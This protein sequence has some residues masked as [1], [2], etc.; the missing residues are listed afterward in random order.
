MMYVLHKSKYFVNCP[1]TFV[2]VA[3]RKSSAAKFP[4]IKE[5]K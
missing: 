1:W 3:T 4:A 5:L 2:F